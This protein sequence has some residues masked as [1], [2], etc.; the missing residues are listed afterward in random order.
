M[1]NQGLM[2]FLMLNG[3]L[4]NSSD[5]LSASKSIHIYGPENGRQLQASRNPNASYVL[6]LASFKNKQNAEA[7]AKKCASQTD[8]HV[9]LVYK[10]SKKTDYMVFIG[11][12][13]G[14]NTLHAVSLQLLSQKH[15]TRTA[16]RVSVSHTAMPQHEDHP[17]VTSQD[18]S[19]ARK[20]TRVTTLSAGFGWYNSGQTQTIA[21][22]PDIE[23]TY[24]AA[25]TNDAIAEG[26]LFV[27]WQRP[28]HAHLLGQAGVALAGSSRAGFSGD[29]WEDA[30]PELSNYTYNYGIQHTHVAIEG[31]LLADMDLLFTPYV[32]GSIGVGFNKAQN[33]VIHPK[34]EEE[35]PAPGFQSHTTTAFTYTAGIGV[36]KALNQHWQAGLGYLFSDWG[37]SQLASAPGQTLNSGIALSHT[38][39]N[40][41]L[42]NLSYL[43]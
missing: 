29:I 9:H 38:Y 35:I 27:G 43:G 30:N 19:T 42:F 20:W 12:L 22:Q 10:P 25:H 1:K 7:Y 39:V 23:K 5:V 31:K 15:T 16:P 40:S 13:T 2:L 8:E 33:F 3:L 26:E 34:L 24:T 14:I 41:V 11:P 32:N 28:L 36:Q 4:L 17:T 37:K 18:P 6:Q 21:I